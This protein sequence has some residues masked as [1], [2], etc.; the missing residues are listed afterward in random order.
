VTG[1]TSEKPLSTKSVKVLPKTQ[2][3]TNRRGPGAT[4]KLSLKMKSENDL[5]EIFPPT[6]GIAKR[7]SNNPEGVGP[8]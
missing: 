3:T 2:G 5:V 4:E 7:S 8:L 6:E 1:A